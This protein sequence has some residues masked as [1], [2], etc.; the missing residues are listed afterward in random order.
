VRHRLINNL[1]TIKRY[2]WFIWCIDV[3][4]FIHVRLLRFLALIFYQ[5]FYF[6]KS[7]ES[8]MCVF[9]IQWEAFSTKSTN[10]RSIIFFCESINMKTDIG[11]LLFCKQTTALQPVA[12]CRQSPYLRPAII[13]VTSFLLWRHSRVSR[14]RRWQLPFSLL[15]HS[16]LSWPRP[17]LQTHGHLTAFIKII[18]N[19]IMFR[20]S[21]YHVYTWVESAER[22]N[23]TF[24][25]LF[26]F[27]SLFKNTFLTF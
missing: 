5:R 18:L 12:T 26:P 6:I 8:C 13:I 2:I 27:L 25:D 15:L 21:S 9:K 11:L 24:A 10:I 20:S 7:C 16:L 1:W 19:I 3:N 14:L 4:F 17:A 23:A 22:F